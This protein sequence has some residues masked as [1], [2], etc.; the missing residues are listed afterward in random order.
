MHLTDHI[1]ELQRITF[2]SHTIRNNVWAI[3]NNI[4]P[5]LFWIKCI[6]EDR[7][8]NLYVITKEIT[9]IA[10]YKKHFQSHRFHEDPANKSDCWRV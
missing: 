1:L 3:P 10:L 4:D 8:E 2:G 7:H 6:V 9:A 5:L